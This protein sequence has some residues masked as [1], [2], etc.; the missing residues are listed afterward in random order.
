M[1]HAIYSNI[2]EKF[3]TSLSP[4]QTRH[5][6]PIYDRN[7]SI[8]QAY[9]PFSQLELPNHIQESNVVHKNVHRREFCSFSLFFHYT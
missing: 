3:Q 6:F 1:G 8:S 9:M 5:A 4:N 2:L 7:N